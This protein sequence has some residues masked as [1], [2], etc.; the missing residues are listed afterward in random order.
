MWLTRLGVLAALACVLAFSLP[1]GAASDPLLSQALSLINTQEYKQAYALLEPL[2]SERAGDIE[3]DYLLGV[4]AVESGNVTRGVFAL[5][6]VLAINPNHTAARTQIAKAH[7]QLGEIDTSK[8][9]FN[10]LLSQSP[11]HETA[12]AINRF[13]SAIDKALGLTTTFGA[14]LDIGYGFDSNINSATS[15]NSVSISLFPGTP[16]VD[17]PLTGAAQEQSSKYISLAG[18]ASFRHPLTKDLAVFGSVNGLTRT[19]WNE[20]QFD[21]SIMDYN[22]GLTY[23][24][25]I[26]M[27]TVGLQGNTYDLD[28]DRF[29]RSYGMLGQWQ[30]DV[31]DKNQVSVYGHYSKLSYPDSDVRDAD[32]YIIGAGWAHVF[33]GD[34]TPVVFFGPY[35]GKE[36]TEDSSFDFLSN[37]IYGIRAGGQLSMSPKLVA[38]AG[39]SYEYR[40]YDEQ[41]PIFS[42]TRRDNQYDFN[43]GLRYLPGYKWTI[44]PQ[45][46]YLKNNSNTTVFDFDRA[47]LSINFRKDFNW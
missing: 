19:N 27:F 29:R 25:H 46:S 16:L 41:D 26:D 17:I 2:E 38:Y 9:E 20:G 36:N 15:S 23:K 37:S 18:G 34:K 30:R 35:I 22:L 4:A 39:A 10:N 33:A 42:E 3:Y 24:K 12:D 40:D 21:P 14:Y 31:D 7:F 44:R 28:G 43:V 47:V 32:R 13:M 8:A 11:G 45:L 1:A 5:E 6:R